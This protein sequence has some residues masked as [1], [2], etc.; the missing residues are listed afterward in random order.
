MSLCDTRLTSSLINSTKLPTRKHGH[1]FICVICV[2]LSLQ[3][4][5]P[6]LWWEGDKDRPNY[7]L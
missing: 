7:V 2:S 1:S 5:W 3:Y 4:M 6:L